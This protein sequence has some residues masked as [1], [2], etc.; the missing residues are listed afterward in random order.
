M[1]T[2]I[3]RQDTNKA[4]FRSRGLNS[5]QIVP[6]QKCLAG[7]ILDDPPLISTSCIA[8]SFLIYIAERF[9]RDMQQLVRVNAES[10]F[11]ISA[12][13]RSRPIYNDEAP[14]IGST[15]I[16]VVPRLVTDTL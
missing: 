1:F 14:L 16:D 8:I 11:A 10:I 4:G 15:P 2:E 5:V 3:G 6:V 13:S 7:E 12:V 9:V